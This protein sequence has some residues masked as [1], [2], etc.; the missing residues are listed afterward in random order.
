MARWTGELAEYM[1]RSRTQ[2]IGSSDYTNSELTDL[3]ADDERRWLRGLQS[4]TLRWVLKHRD[5]AV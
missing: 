4:Y 1:E 5:E 2:Q 3:N